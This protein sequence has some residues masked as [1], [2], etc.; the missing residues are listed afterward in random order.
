MGLL[1]IIVFR[2]RMKHFCS[3]KYFTATKPRLNLNQKDYIFSSLD[4]IV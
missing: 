2:V 3:Q 4:E 1:I